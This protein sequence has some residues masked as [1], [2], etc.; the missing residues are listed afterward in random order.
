MGLVAGLRTFFLLA[1]AVL[2]ESLATP[3]YASSPVVD[4][5]YAKYK[6]YY[7]STADLNVYKG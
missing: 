3:I 1:L 7:N 5:G 4:L 2:P 6:G